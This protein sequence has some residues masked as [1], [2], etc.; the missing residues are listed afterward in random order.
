[1]D[2]LTSAAASGIRSRIESLDMLANN[3]ANASVPGFKADREFYNVYLSSEAAASPDGTTPGLL[4]VIERQWT[5]FT[6]GSLTPTGNPLDL[7]LN[8]QGFFVANSPSG[9]LFTRDGR[10]RLS[11]Q[12][13]L[14]T[15][16]GYAVQDQNGNPILL[17]TSKPIE[18]GPDGTIRQ[19][20]QDVSQIAVV[21]F[22]DPSLLAKRGDNYF[23]TILPTMPPVPALQTEVQQ[24][25][26]EAA[27]S[28]PAQ[29]AVRLVN[30]MRQF[31]T[32]QKAMAIGTEMN[33]S[34][35]QEVAKVTS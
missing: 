34:A 16:D 22:R 11:A 33:R 20:G 21:N 25:K 15:L 13:Q 28:Q 2:P 35:V 6:Q 19:A 3:I 32:L 9:R 5:D 14:Q 8:G 24:G 4:P 31:E 1:M 29:S 7:G 26:I 17:D 23:Q 27:N 10:F 12:G 18:V 30:I